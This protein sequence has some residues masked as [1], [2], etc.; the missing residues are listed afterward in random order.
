MYPLVYMVEQFVINMSVLAGIVWR[1]NKTK[2]K[3]LE[4]GAVSENTAKTPEDLSVDEWYL[5]SAWAKK[6][7]IKETSDGRFYVEVNESKQPENIAVKTDEIDDAD[8]W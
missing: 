6:F 3:L 4:M 5:R 7:G 8:I 1:A 2:E